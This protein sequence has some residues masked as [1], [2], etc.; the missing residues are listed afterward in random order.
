VNDTE[1][2]ELS[3]TAVEEML[4][5]PQQA[6]LNVNSE[7][8][9]S[10]LGQEPVKEEEPDEDADDANPEGEDETNDEDESEEAEQKP[11]SNKAAEKFVKLRRENAKLKQELEEAQKAAPQQEQQEER[12]P[13]RPRPQKKDFDQ[14]DEYIEAVSRWSVEQAEA[15]REAKAE[16]KRHEER[17]GSRAKTWEERQKAATAKYSDYDE[18]VFTDAVKGLKPTQDVADYLNDETEHG[19]EILYKLL[20]DEDL[21]EKFASA[22]SA[23]KIAMIAKIE[24]GLETLSAPKKTA[25]ALPEPPK[26]LPTGR[27]VASANDLMNHETDTAT[28]LRKFDRVYSRKR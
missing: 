19:P 28:W 5:N 13:T 9:K 20:A 4:N 14:Y 16:Q 23:K 18:V 25:K 22:S 21:A 7:E 10:A 1:N 3:I 15:E 2:G 11:K 27:T 8:F 6:T 26:K 12:D 17:M 24:A